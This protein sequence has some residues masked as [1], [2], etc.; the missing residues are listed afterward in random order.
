M[1][2]RWE[3]TE[4]FRNWVHSDLFKRSHSRRDEGRL[5]HGNELR[6][7]EVLDVEVPA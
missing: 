1:L 7:Y 5:A 4:S 3:S 2:T 6:V